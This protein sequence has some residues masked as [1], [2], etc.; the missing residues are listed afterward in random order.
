GFDLMAE[1]PMAPAPL[2]RVDPNGTADVATEP[3]HFPNGAVIIGD[4][5]VVA[6]TFGNRVS[7][8]GIAVDGTL[9]DRRDW[10]VFGPVPDTTEVGEAL[11]RLAVA[12]DGMA[13]DA[14]GAVWIA[15]ALGNRALR[16][17]KG[18]EI[19]AEISTG[20]TGVYA[21]ALGGEDGRTLYLCTAPGFAESE[22]RHTREAKLLATRVEVPAATSPPPLTP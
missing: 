1:A 16:V 15:D 6:E 18:G 9:S 13:L 3:L 10:A 4:E 14:E 8:F 21:V 2:V 5:L 12:P 7:G 19:V 22:R 11:G 17:R 20:D